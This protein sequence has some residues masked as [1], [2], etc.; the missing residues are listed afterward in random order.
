[1]VPDPF[2]QGP[3]DKKADVVEHATVFDHVGLLVKEPP[4]A[5]GLPFI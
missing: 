2:F 4:G 3:S 1:M 5:A